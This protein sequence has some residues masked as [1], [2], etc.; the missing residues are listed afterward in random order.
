MYLK[1]K[2]M[3]FEFPNASLPPRVWDLDL[4]YIVRNYVEGLLVHDVVKTAT[5]G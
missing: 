5:P 4:V 3:N 2:K 1:G